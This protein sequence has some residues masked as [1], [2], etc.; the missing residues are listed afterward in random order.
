VA[1]EGDAATRAARVDSVG[2]EIG[3]H[4]RKPIFVAQQLALAT[5]YEELDV[6]R[7]R[8]IGDAL[9]VIIG[10]SAGVLG[11]YRTNGDVLAGAAS[12]AVTGGIAGLTGGL[13]LGAGRPRT[14]AHPV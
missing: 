13:S 9:R 6:G 14:A 7:R 5:V 11:A 4:L 1:R 3:H 10:A 2:E 12:G 8:L